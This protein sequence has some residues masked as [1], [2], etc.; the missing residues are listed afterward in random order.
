MEFECK[1]IEVGNNHLFSYLWDKF[2]I[3]HLKRG[4]LCYFFLVHPKKRKDPSYKMPYRSFYVLYQ[5]IINKHAPSEYCYWQSELFPFPDYWHD[6]LVKRRGETSVFYCH[7]KFPNFMLLTKCKCL[8][9]MFPKLY[10]G[11]E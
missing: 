2:D 7:V 1:Y 11:I 4:A 5:K 6:F 3:W 10:Q 8:A 9:Q